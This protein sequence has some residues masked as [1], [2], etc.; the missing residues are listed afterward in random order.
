MTLWLYT[1]AP[2]PVEML[3]H[4]TITQIKRK[5]NYFQLHRLSYQ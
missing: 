1:T 2:E 3:T 4:M 5:P